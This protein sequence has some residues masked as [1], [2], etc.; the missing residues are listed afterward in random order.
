MI[1]LINIL[2][3]DIIEST[4]V[5]DTLVLALPHIQKLGDKTMLV[6]ESGGVRSGAA[7]ITAGP[8]N[9]GKIG[10][11]LHTSS[12]VYDAGLG[13]VFND[14]VKKFGI[15][16]IIYASHQAA[17]HGLFGSEYFLIPVGDCKTIWSPE[18]HDIYSDATTMKKNGTLDSFPLDSYKTN[19][20]TGKVDEVLVDCKEYYL[21]SLR[22]P[23]VKSFMEYSAYKNKIKVVP[24]TT[25]AELATLIE[26]VLRKY[27]K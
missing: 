7:R 6:R 9:K 20:P 22:I 17:R 8:W 16:H 13:K 18:I 5:L 24:P 1:K 10:S 12:P 2:S 23:I 27:N 11:V 15:E 26:Q 3:E 4:S 25:Y 21:V 14:L 19:W